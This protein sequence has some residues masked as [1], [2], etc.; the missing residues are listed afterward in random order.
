MLI[1]PL[2]WKEA[3]VANVQRWTA[4]VMGRATY[5]VGVHENGGAYLMTNWRGLSH[6]VFPDFECAKKVAQDDFEN[7][8]SAHLELADPDGLSGVSASSDDTAEKRVATPSPETQ[9]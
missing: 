4:A 1:K 9:R 8:I 6:E 2:E 5:E 3:E 7:R